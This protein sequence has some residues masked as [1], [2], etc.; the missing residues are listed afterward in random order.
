[1]TAWGSQRGEDLARKWAAFENGVPLGTPAAL[2]LRFMRSPV[3]ARIVRDTRQRTD[4]L[5]AR[6]LAIQPLTN[7]FARPRM[8]VSFVKRSCFH[9]PNGKPQ[10]LYS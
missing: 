9:Q 7:I 2:H 3:A 4:A 1:M 8:L 10:A 6:L 5:A